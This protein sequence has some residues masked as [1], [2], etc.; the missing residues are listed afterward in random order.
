MV[1]SGGWVRWDPWEYSTPVWE[2]KEMKKYL[3]IMCVA[4]VA[5]A[6]NAS[7]V[8]DEGVD[9]DLSNDEF[10]ATVL[11]L[12][13]GSNN[14]I[15]NIG[16]VGV[17]F[18]DAMEFTIGAGETL[19]SVTLVDFVVSGGNIATGFNVFDGANALLGSVSMSTGDIGSD[20]LALSGV[21]QLGPGTYIVVMREGVLDQDYEISYNLIPAPASMAL[22]GLGGLVATRRRR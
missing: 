10:N 12:S 1:S 15:A 20:L 13:M 4:G 11:G 18:N 3:A 2:R 16:G 7:V 5:C 21:N 6:A 22:L 17:D 14:V 19:A 9:G 8:W